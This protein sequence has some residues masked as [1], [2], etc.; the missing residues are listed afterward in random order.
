MINY[1][2][3]EVDHQT[4]DHTATHEV[5]ISNAVTIFEPAEATE[6]ITINLTIDPGVN[7]GALLLCKIKTQG[8]ETTTFG[9]NMLGAGLTGVAGKTL[10][11]AFM[12]TGTTFDAIGAFEQID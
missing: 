6:N 8:T 7:E 12:F 10:T 9:T 4:P 1:P 2:F 3:G 5:T 11:K